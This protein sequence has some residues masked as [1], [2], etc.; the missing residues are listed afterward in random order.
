MK[1]IALCFDQSGIRGNAAVLGELLSH[2]DRQLVWA[3]TDPAAEERPARSL[4]RRRAREVNTTRARVIEAYDHLTE[5]WEP[6]DRVF[7]FGAGRGGYCARAFTRLLGTVGVLPRTAEDAAPELREY[8]LATY[9]LPRTAREP[10]DWQRISRLAATL[11]GREDASVGVDFLGL[12]DT[13]AVPGLPRRNGPDPLSRVGAARHALAID[14]QVAPVLLGHSHSDVEEVWFR[15]AHCDIIR[16][17]HACTPLADIALDWVLDGAIAAGAEVADA[18]RSHTP[19]PCAVD[20]LAGSTHPVSLRRIPAGAS[21]HASV[22]CY[23]RAHPSYWRRLPAHIAWADP[24]WV[25]RGER[26][27]AAPLPIETSAARPELAS[28]S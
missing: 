28:A 1:N 9:A 14:A 15:G 25:A 4:R 16:G 13:V 10:A 3:P 21:V 8:V 20:A 27:M 2:T 22:D 6:G 17:R 26:L 5:H 7:V 24:D 23:L 11:S 18:A 12:W 19:A